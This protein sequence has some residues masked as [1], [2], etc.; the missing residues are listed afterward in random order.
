MAIY[1]FACPNCGGE[2]EHIMSWSK[3]QNVEIVCGKC[4]IVKTRTITMPAKTADAWNGRWNEGLRGSGT[5]DPALRT[6]I[7]SE[8][9]RDQVL[10][11]K[12]LIRESDL[13]PGFIE[14]NQAKIAER[15]AEQDALAAQYQKVLAETG[16]AEKAMTETFTAEKCLDGTLDKT[17][18]T[19]LD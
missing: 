11:S 15:D 18:S 16:D 8:K 1:N 2:S 10:E 3:V 4:S 9:H 14:D 6:T 7:Y 12:G 5:W 17:Y 13:R 19:E